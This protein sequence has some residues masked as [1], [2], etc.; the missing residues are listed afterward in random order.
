M[1][2]KVRYVLENKG[3]QVWTVGKEATV[4]QATLLM[5]E[6]KIGALVVTEAGRIAGMFTERDVL[7]RV[8]GEQRD[9]AKTTVAEIM[10][11][12]VF[13]CSLDTSLDEAGGAMKNHRIRHLPVVDDDGGLLGLI[14]IGD[15]NAYRTADQEQTIFLLHEYLHGRV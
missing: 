13:C 2:G 12:D 6:H 9:P 10:S 7:R 15:I 3:R 14:S 8:V 5:N 4:L 1:M 11:S